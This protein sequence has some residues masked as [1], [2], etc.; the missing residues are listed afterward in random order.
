MSL[1]KNNCIHVNISVVSSQLRSGKRTLSLLLRLGLKLSFVIKLIVRAGS[2]NPEPLHHF[3]SSYPAVDQSAGGSYLDALSTSHLTSFLF[4]FH[5][6]CFLFLS[7]FYSFGAMCFQ[8]AAAG[9]FFLANVIVYGITS[10]FFSLS[11]FH[12]RLNG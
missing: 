2:G 1:C 10:Q 9:P 12:S 4:F 6:F 8:I 11:T 5:H 3:H 7:L